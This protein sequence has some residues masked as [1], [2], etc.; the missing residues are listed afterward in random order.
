MELEFDGRTIKFE[1]ELSPLDRLVLKFVK[2][3]DNAAVDYV[4][5]SGYIAILFGR[6]RNTEDVDLFIEKMPFEKFLRLWKE[7][8]NAGFECINTP[9]PKEAYENYLSDGL[10]IRFA[11]RGEVIP[12]FEV[13]FPKTDLNQYSLRNKIIVEL[14]GERLSTSKMELQ[15]AFK[16]YLGSDKDIEDAIHIW[17]IFKGRLDM[18]LFRGFA[19]KL[20]VEDK[21]KLLG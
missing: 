8:Y 11:T 16:L 21:I 20:G 12:N 9:E 13:K 15:I 1:R 3:L 18:A 14:N 19:R 6:S 2:I 5:I 10:A 4:I 17:E 7:L